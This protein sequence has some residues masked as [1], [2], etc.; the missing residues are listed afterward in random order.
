MP[1]LCKSTSA[2]V[3]AML[4]SEAQAGFGILFGVRPL[5]ASGQLRVVAITA[6]K[7]SPAALDI[8]KVAEAGVP[9]YEVD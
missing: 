1:L 8:P 2:V 5:M 4:S 6:G 3:M 7:R 9:G